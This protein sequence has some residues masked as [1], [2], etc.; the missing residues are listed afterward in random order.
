M[1]DEIK[2]AA[3][4][5]PTLIDELVTNYLDWRAYNKGQNPPDRKEMKEIFKK[6]KTPRFFA[7]S[8]FRKYIWQI[9]SM[10]I[11]PTRAM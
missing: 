5:V 9:R 10:I 1:E 8:L 3:A 2:D 11:L 7:Y 4:S 6:K